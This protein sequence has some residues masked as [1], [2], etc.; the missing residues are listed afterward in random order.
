MH[1]E[2]GPNFS[3]LVHDLPVP[4]LLRDIATQAGGSINFR[5]CLNTCTEQKS[6]YSHWNPYWKFL[7]FSIYDEDRTKINES[8]ISRYIH[9]NMD[10]TSIDQENW[11]QHRG[12]FWAKRW[13]YCCCVEGRWGGTTATV[14]RNIPRQGVELD[15]PFHPNPFYDS[16]MLWSFSA[17]IH[18]P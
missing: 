18:K 17:N 8:S 6:P 2:K 12:I 4:G 15:N 7:N 14:L 9:K 11:T 10:D 1:R 5:W 13:N 3:P 16:T